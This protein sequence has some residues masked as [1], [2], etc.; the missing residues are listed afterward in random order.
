MSELIE[1]LKKCKVEKNI[2]FL[3]SISEGP[4]ANYADV[5]KALLNAGA[6]YKKNTFVFKTDAQPFMDR[7]TGGES[8]N[9]KKEFQFFA[10][11]EKLAKQLVDYALEDLQSKHNIDVLEPS[12]GD[13]ALVKAFLKAMNHGNAPDFT[14]SG[15]ELMPENQQILEDVP[16]FKL[17]GPDFL[18][19]DTNY[20]FDCI[21]ANPPFTKGQ[22]MEHIMHM[23]KCLR[24]GG[25]LVSIASTHFQ[26]A[27]DKKA[28]VF[29]EFL[30]GTEVIIQDVAK[31]A[32][33]ESGTGVNTCIIKILK[34]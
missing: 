21:I 12:A 28:K 1:S 22:D 32:F 7:L 24:P 19:H 13:G 34:Y 4:L 6:T 14:I 2:V 16:Y 10:T 25:V 15:Y 3:P 29:N 26:F 18:K 20:K 30:D 11:P 33:K 5:R 9:I 23:Y 17:L 27:G 8:V 31:G